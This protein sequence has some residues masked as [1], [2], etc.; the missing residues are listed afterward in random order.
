M[1]QD[2]GTKSKNNHHVTGPLGTCTLHL[3]VSNLLFYHL[4]CTYPIFDEN[5]QPKI[6]VK[7]ITTPF[8]TGD[9]LN[10]YFRQAPLNCLKR[11]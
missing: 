9:Q 1:R 8:K 11:Y 5:N 7:K 10:R 6:S 2:N 3:P 4:H